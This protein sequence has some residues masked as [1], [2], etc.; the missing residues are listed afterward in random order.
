RA[1]VLRQLA[2]DDEHVETRTIVAGRDTAEW[3]HDCPDVH[4]HVRH[5][6]APVFQ[7]FDPARKPSCLGHRYVT[8]LPLADAARISR[9]RLEWIGSAG[10]ATVDK[11]T[12]VDTR[13]GASSPL[14]PADRSLT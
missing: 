9:I 10:I 5:A 2:T 1:P 8:V 6:R 7:N 4:P 12:L 3:A 14:I 11:M 13:H